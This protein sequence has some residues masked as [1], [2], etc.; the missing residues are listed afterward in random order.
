MSILGMRSWPQLSS[1]CLWMAFSTTKSVARASC[2]SSA[3]NTINTA[4]KISWFLPLVFPSWLPQGPS[5]RRW[6]DFH[7]QC[8]CGSDMCCTHYHLPLVLDRFNCPGGTLKFAIK[9]WVHMDPDGWF[10]TL[11]YQDLRNTLKMS[12]LVDQVWHRKWGWHRWW[13]LPLVHTICIYLE[14]SPGK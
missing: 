3:R 2:Y 7:F 10:V 8:G 13:C 1:D 14:F 4:S 6:G 9:R 11:L 5:A 12:P